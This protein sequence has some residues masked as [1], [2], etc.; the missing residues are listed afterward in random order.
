MRLLVGILNSHDNWFL[1]GDEKNMGPLEKQWTML[2]SWRRQTL[3]SLLFVFIHT[4]K[5]K[6]GMI[7]TTDT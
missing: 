5:K 7:W 1:G 4:I 6:Q 2:R 3:S